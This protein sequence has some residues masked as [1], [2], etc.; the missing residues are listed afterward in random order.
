MKNKRFLQS[1]RVSSVNAFGLIT[2]IVLGYQRFI[3]TN[4]DTK[5]TRYKDLQ[6]DAYRQMKTFIDEQH[7][8]SV[9]VED[10]Q[11]GLITVYHPNTKES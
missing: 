4:E 7:A 9:R 1:L 6:R 10:T 5:E 2:E 3:I 11:S 8:T